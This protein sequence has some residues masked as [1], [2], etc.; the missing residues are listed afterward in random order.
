MPVSSLKHLLPIKVSVLFLIISAFFARCTPKN[1]KY[2]TIDPVKNEVLKKQFPKYPN[3]L[4]HDKRIH[5]TQ[6]LHVFTPAIA[7]KEVWIIPAGEDTYSFI[8]VVDTRRTDFETLQAWKIGMIIKPVNPLDFESELLQSK[9]IK[10]IGVLTNLYNM[11]D[12]V[13]VMLHNFKLKPKNLS[14]IK[15]Y[16]YNNE[17]NT[18]LNYWIAKNVQLN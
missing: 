2:T 17:G 3:L 4:Q 10:T 16:L 15:F 9:G 14:Y 5:L 11:G 18:N 1:S 7:F 6:K 13:V 12:E 8:W